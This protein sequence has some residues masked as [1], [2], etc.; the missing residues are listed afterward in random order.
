MTRSVPPSEVIVQFPD[1]SVEHYKISAQ[2]IITMD[3]YIDGKPPF[4][5]ILIAPHM[6]LANGQKE[7]I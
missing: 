4:Y 6:P 5:T 1:G 3:R 2:D 7:A